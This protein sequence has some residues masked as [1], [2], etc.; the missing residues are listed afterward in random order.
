MKNHVY[1]SYSAQQ[2]DEDDEDVKEYVS[3]NEQTGS[4]EVRPDP[5]SALGCVYIQEWTA[6]VTL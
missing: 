4:S 3:Y 1:Q 6:A 2:D 5:P